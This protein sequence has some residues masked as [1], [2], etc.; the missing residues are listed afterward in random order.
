VR[1]RWNCKLFG[2]PVEGWGRKVS[3]R[4]TAGD[5]ARLLFRP[6]R[7]TGLQVLHFCGNH[8]FILEDALMKNCRVRRFV[9]L[10]GIALG[11]SMA[12][13][14]GSGQPGASVPPLMPLPSHI[15]V[16]A[17]QFIVDG[18]LSVALEGY[19]E[20]RLTLARDRFLI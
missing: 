4:E 10:F 11:F 2:R 18:H 3:V 17:G 8:R 6:P 16:G 1:L 20:P 13:L 9:L 7:N 15:E 12:V 19:T 14:Q 5:A